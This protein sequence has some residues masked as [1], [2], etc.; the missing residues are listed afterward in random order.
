MGSP[1]LRNLLPHVA[2]RTVASELFLEA[3]F[4][5]P[6]ALTTAIAAQPNDAI[7]AAGYGAAVTEARHVDDPARLAK[8]AKHTSIQ[9][10]R[11][12]GANPATPTDIAEYL[13]SWAIKK[14]DDELATAL[15]EGQ[16]CTQVWR[17]ID[18]FDGFGKLIE[19]RKFARRL[20]DVGTPDDIMRVGLRTGLFVL[21]VDEYADRAPDAPASVPLSELAAKVVAADLVDGPVQTAAGTLANGSQTLAYDTPDTAR[22]L[23]MLANR[24]GEDLIEYTAGGDHYGYASR[25]D[26]AR[27]KPVVLREVLDDE[28]CPSW[29]QVRL[30]GGA[31]KSTLEALDDAHQDQV[32]RLLE[33]QADVAPEKCWR[34]AAESV[35]DAI[36]AFRAVEL[37][38]RII[39]QI[40]VEH[41]LAVKLLDSMYGRHA[42]SRRF[43]GLSADP[44]A[45]RP[46]LD[47]DRFAISAELLFGLLRDEQLPEHLAR[48]AARKLV[49]LDVDQRK[50]L[51]YNASNFSEQGMFAVVDE[52]AGLLPKLAAVPGVGR[53]LAALLTEQFGDDTARWRSFE[54]LLSD[55]D[56]TTM[57]LVDTVHALHGPV[58]RAEEP[59]DVTEAVDQEAA[60]E[61]T[62]EVAPDLHP[63]PEV[64]GVASAPE[65]EVEVKGE[66]EVEVEGSG[67]PEAKETP[68]PT[69][70]D[71][72]ASEPML[73]QLTLL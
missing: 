28:A 5:D 10:R 13:A 23:V 12:V 65:A 35:R 4:T 53:R 64:E 67:V 41:Q 9:V 26:P 42:Q 19:V 57:G 34:P 61:L 73:T 33:Q 58:E 37:Q 29:Y 60:A 51:A 56:G 31:P 17:L 62:G 55:W 7:K 22:A 32:V 63:G 20:L 38:R 39:A 72:P 36:D 44:E 50:N 71:T 69:V 25:K 18:E 21:L 49:A 2:S 66:V 59:A 40:A 6:T 68:S 8:L 27:P 14:G 30:I 70:Q 16:P 15:V 54:S 52:F 45:L 3:G 43:G 1:L 47:Q 46:L 11:A 24:F 48:L